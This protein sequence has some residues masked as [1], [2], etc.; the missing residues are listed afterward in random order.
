MDGYTVLGCDQEADLRRVT[1]AED[2]GSVLDVSKH[3]LGEMAWMDQSRENT[4]GLSLFGPDA[5]SLSWHLSCGSLSIIL[6]ICSFEPSS[7][8]LNCNKYHHSVPVF[9][10]LCCKKQG[11]VISLNFPV[12]KWPMPTRQSVTP[13]SQVMT[14]TVEPRSIRII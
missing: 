9:K 4:Q 13:R 1:S 12:G 10:V 2:H 14:L 8:I 5:S 11:L 7:Y 3:L 6:A